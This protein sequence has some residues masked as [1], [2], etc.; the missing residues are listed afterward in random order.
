MKLVF[1]LHI[2]VNSSANSAPAAAREECNEYDLTA[3]PCFWLANPNNSSRW[4]AITSSESLFKFY[5]WGY[6]KKKELNN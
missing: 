4:F 2:L 5:G 3:H 1:R 6:Q